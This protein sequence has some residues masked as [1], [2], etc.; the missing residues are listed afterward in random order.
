VETKFVGRYEHSL[1]VKGRV[2]LPARYRPNFGATAF[3]SKWKTRCLAIWTPERFE[4]RAEQMSVLLDGTVEEQSIARSFF[5]GSSE[6][7]L[8]KQGRVFVPQYLRGYATLAENST[9]LV[10][11]MYDHIELWS[12]DSWEQQEPTGDAFLGGDR[13]T[14]AAPAVGA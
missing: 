13:T 4:A 5:S 6:V 14:V 3:V 2:I 8:D 1:D 11:G 9:V 12:P 10:V 7:D